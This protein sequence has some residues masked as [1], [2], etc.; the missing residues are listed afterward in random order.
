MEGPFERDHAPVPGAVE[1]VAP[2]VRCVTAPNA[3]PM[4]F[5]GTRTYLV[6]EGEVAVIDPG[7]DDPAHREAVLG[8]LRPGE[9]VGAVLV[10]HAHR[11]HSG[12][13]HAL[14]RAS[15]APVRGHGRPR[16]GVRPLAA[17]WAAVGAL[18][19]GE[20]IDAGFRPERLGDGEAVEGEGWRLVALHTP[21]HLGDHLCFAWEEAGVLFSGDVLMGWSTT[22]I[23]PPEGDLGAFTASLG[24]LA[25]RPE[26]LF[27]PGHGAP[28]RDPKG[29][30]EWQLA[31][32]RERSDQIASV[33]EKGPATVGEIVEA[34]YRGLDPALKGAAGRNV[35]A[36]LLA[37]AERGEVAVEGM[38]GAGASFRIARGVPPD[39]GR[40]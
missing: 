24:R 16:E 20:G 2:G 7:P 15:D 34:V 13:A 21:G 29:M 12:G 27:L 5:T 30:I 9:R 25:A 33:L 38:P 26:R 40:G 28:L 39:G 10:T 31:H 19:G 1:Q 3:G 18:G 6:G 37:M 11:D 4:T 22:L 36:H 32:R 8:A 17:S 14:G 35:L 23:S